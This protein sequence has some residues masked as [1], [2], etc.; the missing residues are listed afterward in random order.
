MLALIGR[1]GLEILC[2][3]STAG[4]RLGREFVPQFIVVPFFSEHGMLRWSFRQ[5]RSHGFWRRSDM[6]RSS[7]RSPERCAMDWC[8]MDRLLGRFRYSRRI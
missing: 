8:D 7:T 1:V 6:P 5:V 2:K 4:G 3:V